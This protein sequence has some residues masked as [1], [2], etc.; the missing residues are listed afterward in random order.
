MKPIGPRG[1][2]SGFD[3]AAGS[4]ATA[5]G[6]LD[7]V[8][9]ASGTPVGPETDVPPFSD[10]LAW[11]RLLDAQAEATGHVM[12]HAAWLRAAARY[13][14]EN[15]RPLRVVLLTT[16]GSNEGRPT[17]QAVTQIARSVN[18][19]TMPVPLDVFSVTV[20]TM[21]P[22]DLAAASHL[23]ARLAG[24]D[25]SPAL[26]GAELVVGEL[27]VGG[28]WLGVRSHPEP[29]MTVS[30]GGPAIPSFVADAMGQAVRGGIPGA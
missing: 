28:G 5:A 3:A 23:A 13:A 29:V 20:E 4:I 10:P 30:F 9:V 12:F 19:S 7:A 25:D 8:V 26:R 16:V 22:S 2:P 18:D 27:V 17:A 6:P 1:V 11:M 14:F 24:A 21:R 15:G